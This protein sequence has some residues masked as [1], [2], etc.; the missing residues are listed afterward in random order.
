MSV[1]LPE[2]SPAQSRKYITFAEAAAYLGKGRS[3]LYAL[4]GVEIPFYQVGNARMFTIA[5]LDE[6]IESQ[7]QD[8][9]GG[10]SKRRKVNGARRR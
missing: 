4:C 2:A 7:R 9:Y 6:W 1:T 3:T 8:I 5:D 10:K